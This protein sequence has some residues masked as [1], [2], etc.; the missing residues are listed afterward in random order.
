MAQK[1]DYVYV[2][3]GR[4]T[5][6]LYLVPHSKLFLASIPITVEKDKMSH[7]E[8]PALYQKCVGKSAL[9]LPNGKALYKGRYVWA[10]S[11]VLLG[12]S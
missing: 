7:V 6:F 5:F 2:E 12:D 10:Y 4:G 9:L 1:H 11:I 3:S 8:Y